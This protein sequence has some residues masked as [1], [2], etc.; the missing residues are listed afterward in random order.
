MSKSRGNVVNPDIM[1]NAYGADAFRLYEL[2]M[3]PFDQPIPWSTQGL[4][5][6]SRFLQRVWDLQ[7]K[8]DLD[9]TVDADTNRLVHQTIREVGERI[10]GM[11]F[12]TAVS[13]LMSLANRL[14]SAD[15][16]RREDWERFLLLLAPFAPHIAEE[17]WQRQGYEECISNQPW[18][19]FDPEQA[20]EDLLEIPIQ[21]NGKLRARVTVPAD[22]DETAI[23]ELARAE[24][25]GY[26]EGHTIRKVIFVRKGEKSLVNFVVG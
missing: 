9:A 11:K 10:E 4:V 7:E 1:V 15:R 18:P 3:G 21:V 16:I 19:K 20:A 23:K 12:N 24:V 14:G 2:F 8:V 22:L 13:S 25:E 17:L 26:I 6:M 5:G